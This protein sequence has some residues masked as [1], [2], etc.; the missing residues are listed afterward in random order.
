MYIPDPLREAVFER[1]NGLCEYCQTNQKIVVTMEIDHIMPISA[2][3]ETVLENLC[4]ACQGCNRFKRD[5]Q[6]GFDPETNQEYPLFNPRI[7]IWTDHFQWNENTTRLVGIS[8][9]GRATI[10]RL[11]INRDAVVMARQIWVQA[12]W[13]PPQ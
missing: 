8:T 5:F 12:G 11:Q 6:F 7:Q 2:G 3:G 1:A 10:T 13:H 4:L 9:I